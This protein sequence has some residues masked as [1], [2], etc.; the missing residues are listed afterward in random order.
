MTA[1]EPRNFDCPTLE[2]PCTDKRC[3]T[4]HCVLRE[5]ARVC[6]AEA[7]VKHERQIDPDSERIIRPMLRAL[8]GKKNQGK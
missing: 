5:K 8:R 4:E 6:A 3:S 1:Q 2:A 7:A